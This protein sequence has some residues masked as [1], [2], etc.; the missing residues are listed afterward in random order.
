MSLFFLFALMAEAKEPNEIRNHFTMT[1]VPGANLLK[2]KIFR[3]RQVRAF[4]KQPASAVAALAGG[5]FFTAN[6]L[7]CR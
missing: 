4:P 7:Q 6:S 2:V 1:A 3:S 5:L